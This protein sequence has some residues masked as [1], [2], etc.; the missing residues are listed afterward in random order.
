MKITPISLKIILI[1]VLILSVNEAFPQGKFEISGGLGLPALSNLR[2][3]YGTDLQ[4]GACIGLGVESGYDGNKFAIWSVS[5][6]INYHFSGKSK[7]VDQHPWYALAGLGCF[8]LA[9][10]KG[11]E[12]YDIGFYPGIGRT[13]NFSKRIGINCDIGVFLP[14]SAAPNQ[15][16]NFKILPA[17]NISFFIRL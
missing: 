17:G 14:L 5:A 11:Y 16:F 10:V 13:L 15:Q 9:W 7:Y 3:K 8:D 6:E 2:I 1:A 12:D 4:I